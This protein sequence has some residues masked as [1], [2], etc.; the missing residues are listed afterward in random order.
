MGAI[1]TVTVQLKGSKSKD[2]C[3]IN[4]ADYDPE[5]HKLVMVKKS[6]EEEV[7]SDDDGEASEEGAKKEAG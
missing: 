4:E 1:P 6:V 7:A 5:I 3:V 2:T